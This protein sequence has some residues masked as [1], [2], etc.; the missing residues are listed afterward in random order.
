MNATTAT[1]SFDTVLSA[2]WSNCEEISVNVLSRNCRALT[3]ETV[4]F[5]DAKANTSGRLL[6]LTPIQQEFRTH[7]DI[8]IQTSDVIRTLFLLGRLPKD[9][10]SEIISP[11]E[12]KEIEIPKKHSTAT[13]ERGTCTISERPPNEMCL[14]MSMFPCESV[15]DISHYLE[16]MCFADVFDLLIETN[17]RVNVF[18]SAAEENSLE[19]VFPVSVT[20]TKNMSALSAAD[21]SSTNKY[22]KD[23]SR[24]VVFEEAERARTRYSPTPGEAAQPGYYRMELSL[25]M[26]RKLT[27]L[28]GSEDDGVIQQIYVD[29]P[30]WR[31]REI[32]QAWKGLPI[33]GYHEEGFQCDNFYSSFPCH[34]CESSVE[35]QKSLTSPSK[36]MVIEPTTNQKSAKP[37]RLDTA[38]RL[39]L[40]QLYEE[41]SAVDHNRIRECFEDTGFSLD[42]T[43]VVLDSFL[44]AED[45]STFYNTVGHT[46]VEQRRV[47]SDVR[48]SEH[49]QY[50]N[51]EGIKV[52]RPFY[53]EVHLAIQPLH[54]EVDHCI[55]KRDEFYQKA[56]ISKDPCVKQFYSR[57]ALNFSKRAKS[58]KE[59]INSMIVE[60]N[61]CST[62]VDLHGMNVS[63]A[64]QLLKEK[65]TAL[66]RP[67]HLRSSRSECKVIVVT[68]YGKSSKNVCTLKPAVEQWLNQCN[69]E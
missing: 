44:M 63:P 57:E 6:S 38:S 35:R 27:Q 68:G 30:L 50:V 34:L 40:N 19:G 2:E 49:D 60:A 67:E 47:I 5:S 21:V 65:L 46:P 22:L 26:I 43:R 37:H 53:S 42:H 24:D 62:Y 23:A 14:L 59:K 32:Y 52:S 25:D 64:I 18:S 31:W 15:A 28:F 29:L 1:T 66:D 3:L 69:Y 48:R 41:Y 10:V 17:A 9:L 20:E 12:T 58:L 39:K 36:L 55:G 51:P 4:R 33:T 56:N 45:S 16:M 54:D 13:K 7:V 11:G 8:G 61:N